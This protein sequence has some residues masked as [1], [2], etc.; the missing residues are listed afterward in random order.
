M[1]KKFKP[2]WSRI[3]KTLND[4]LVAANGCLAVV[5]ILLASLMFIQ[6]QI[7]SWQSGDTIGSVLSNVGMDQAIVGLVVSPA[8]SS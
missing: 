2:R 7:V 5:A 3:E 1:D 4:V 6:L 8:R